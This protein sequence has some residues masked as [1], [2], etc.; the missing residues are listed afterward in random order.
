MKE[1][2][3]EIYTNGH[4]SGNPGPGGWEFVVT[5]N[6]RV[7]KEACGTEEDTTHNRMEMQA[8]IRALE[9][10]R[11][12]NACIYSDSL[13]TVKVFNGKWRGKKDLDLV[14]AGCALL[15][16]GDAELLWN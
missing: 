16:N 3:I 8:V 14:R 15:A 13:L 12:R 10:L 9:W 1:E 11:G 7:V 5:E 6:G 2:R 4:C